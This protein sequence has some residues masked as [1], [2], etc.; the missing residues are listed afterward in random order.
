MSEPTL[1]GIH[2]AAIIPASPPLLP[3]HERVSLIGFLDSPKIVLFV[4]IDN[5][6]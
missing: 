3:P 5:A 4:W 6:D 2:P 1:K